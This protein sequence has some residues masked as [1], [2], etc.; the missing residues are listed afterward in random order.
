[1]RV[2]WFPL[3]VGWMLERAHVYCCEI[4]FY[5]R[6][7]SSKNNKT[8]LIF[9]FG[10]L[11]EQHHVVLCCDISHNIIHITSRAQN[12]YIAS[13]SNIKEIIKI[14]DTFPKLSSS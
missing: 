8:Y 11:E 4:M 9:D 2:E 7:N 1:M 14:K 6:G 3:G 13:K 10:S 5:N 12:A